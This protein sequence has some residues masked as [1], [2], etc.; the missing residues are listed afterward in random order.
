MDK[1]KLIEQAKDPKYISGIY[2]Y[3]DRWCE[4]CQ[5][6]SRCLNCAL[7]EEQFGDLE[8]NDIFNEAFWERFAEVLHDTYTMI[9]EMAIEEGI[10]IDSID[11]ENDKDIETIKENSFADFIFYTSNKYAKAVNKWFDEN[12]NLFHEKEDEMNRIRLISSPT[13]PVKEAEDINDAIDIVR[14]YQYQIHVK[15]RR[16]G[17]SAADEAIDPSDFPKDS[18]GSA[19]VAL[20]GIDRSMSAWKILMAYFPEQKKQIIDLIVSLENLKNSIEIRFPHAREFV[21]PG[22]DEIEYKR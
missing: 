20:I 1:D 8:E 16:A 6:T 15:L 13:N 3:C 11:D 9:K 4:R 21:R 5:F 7:V 10:D 18:E 17:D 14:W 19:K 22:F 2:N 12:E